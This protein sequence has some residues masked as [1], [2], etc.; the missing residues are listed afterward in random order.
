LTFW[1]FQSL[2]VDY[3]GQ[4]GQQ[5]GAV[6]K[7][8]IHGK[9]NIFCVEGNWTN[10]L[11]NN[12]SLQSALKFI[13]L[14]NDIKYIHRNCSTNEQL[15]DLLRHA[16]QK[17]YAK[18]GI[19]YLAFHGHPGFLQVTEKKKMTLETIAQIVDGHAVNKIIHFG[20]C[21]TLKMSSAALGNFFKTT[22][23][24]A[25]SG[26]TKDITFRKSMLMDMAYF[27]L[28]QQYQN[29]KSIDKALQRYYP[30]LVEELGFR[31]YYEA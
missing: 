11:E 16:A 19:I 4:E 26:Y 1:S 23:A 12:S 20:S 21:S 8:A 17:K 24:L 6:M 5:K 31:M 25:I 7:R 2:F 15:E 10:N 22:K 3:I 13:S 29:I 14:N 30:K 18:Y 9:K 28:C 27:E